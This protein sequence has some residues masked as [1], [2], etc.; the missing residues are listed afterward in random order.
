MSVRSLAVAV[1]VVAGCSKAAQVRPDAPPVAVAPAP[2][3]AVASDV[4]AEPEVVEDLDRSRNSAVA[5]PVVMF[6][7]DSTEL[8]ASERE[9]L[10]AWAS[11]IRETGVPTSTVAVTIEGHCDER[12]TEEYNLVLGEKRA[13]A[14][15]TYLGRMGLDL[16]KIRT[17]SYGE[18]RPARHERSEEAF[19][20]NRRAEVKVGASVPKATSKKPFAGR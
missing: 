15:R 8:S 12:G 18:S 9:R 4:A 10:A 16:S 2:V 6:G 3:V 7:F 17:V 13:S 5:P 11:V 1:I 14:V 20:A 19:A